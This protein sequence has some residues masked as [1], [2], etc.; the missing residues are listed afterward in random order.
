TRRSSALSVDCDSNPM[1]SPDGRQLMFMRRPGTAFGSMQQAPSGPSGI[2]PQTCGR[3][4][5]PASDT[6]L[7]QRHVPGLYDGVLPG[8]SVLAIMTI[9]VA[10]IGDIDAPRARVL[11]QNEPGDASFTRLSRVRRVGDH[12][13]FQMNP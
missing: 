4:G 9:D 6:T 13:V 12:I 7:N 10:D 1:W 11:W 2:R 8:G 3:G 5:A